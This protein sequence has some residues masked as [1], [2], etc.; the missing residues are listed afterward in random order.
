MAPP[1]QPIAE[2]L[3]PELLPNQAPTLENMDSVAERAAPPQ[4]DVKSLPNDTE[5]PRLPSN[6][7][8][9]RRSTRDT[10]PPDRLVYLK[11]GGD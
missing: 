1:A 4:C 10:R 6:T 5:P 7:E 3:N 2:L 11:K 9:P 8:P